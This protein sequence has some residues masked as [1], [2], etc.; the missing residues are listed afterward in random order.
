[1]KKFQCK[2]LAPGVMEHGRIS[3]SKTTAKKNL[4]FNL[5]KPLWQNLKREISGALDKRKET[6]YDE[7]DKLESKRDSAVSY[8]SESLL[9]DYKTEAQDSPDKS[10]EALTKVIEEQRRHLTKLE[11]LQKQMR[12]EMGLADGDVTVIQQNDPPTSGYVTGR[13]EAANQGDDAVSAI[14]SKYDH[15]VTAFIILMSYSVCIF[16]FYIT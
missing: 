15:T 16:V 10:M 9:S 5:L 13:S 6:I 2:Y 4:V 12:K 7:I 1:M 8:E 11:L 3:Q 14:S